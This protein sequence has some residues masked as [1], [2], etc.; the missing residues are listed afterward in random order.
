MNNKNNGNRRIAILV[1]ALIAMTIG[2]TPIA[3]SDYTLGVFGNANEDDTVNMQD[4]TYIE[5]IILDYRDQ[6]ELADS[7]YDGKINMQDVTQTELIILG[8]EK[9]LTLLDVDSE[10]V[11]LT[12][13]VRII[14][15]GCYVM[16]KFSNVYTWEE[17]HGE[18]D[19]FQDDKEEPREECKIDWDKVVGISY[20]VP[21][22]NYYA[23][24]QCVYD[25]WIFGLRWT[26]EDDEEFFKEKPCCCSAEG[27]L[28][29]EEIDK[30]DADLF[31][32]S[33]ED[34]SRYSNEDQLREDLKDLGITYLKLDFGSTY[35]Q[36]DPV[37]WKTE[38]LIRRYI[39]N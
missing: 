32:T 11:I 29:I 3:A 5:N 30:I 16:H 22:Y 8:K 13:P 4:V 31:L 33:T 10:H 25:H 6:T 20:P 7:K 17:R 24:S 35:S 34:A 1:I 12:K 26:Y 21:F 36:E 23:G 2:A 27:E 9:E 18:G 38:W 14:L 39:I 15:G 28:N 37:A 19:G